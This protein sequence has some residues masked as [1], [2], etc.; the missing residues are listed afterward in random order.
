MPTTPK[1]MT[2][3]EILA[4]LRAKVGT[5]TTA[6]DFSTQLSYLN[7]A[8]QAATSKAQQPRAAQPAPTPQRQTTIAKPGANNFITQLDMLRAKSASAGK[9]QNPWEVEP[10]KGWV[11]PE[12]IQR[13]AALQVG[14]TA[15]VPVE[16]PP[17]SSTEQLVELRNQVLDAQTGITMPVS[18]DRPN[19]G[20]PG[21][22]MTGTVS[23]GQ[24]LTQ[25]SVSL[26][27]TDEQRLAALGSPREWLDRKMNPVDAI[28]EQWDA[29]SEYYEPTIQQ[30]QE[31]YAAEKELSVWDDPVGFYKNTVE[32]FVSGLA[33][34]GQMLGDLAGQIPKPDTSAT[35]AYLN[36]NAALRPTG[37]LSATAEEATCA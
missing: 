23:G 35:E 34:A 10:L 18:I 1:K 11:S 26:E 22:G 12:P 7:Q 31:R 4:E 37:S 20:V 9:K 8:S 6:N 5:P 15:R 24:T 32:G 3:E 2:S 29:T 19:T 17:T 25:P 13:N 16:G 28:S 33:T 21:I 27:L 36:E 30:A 14:P